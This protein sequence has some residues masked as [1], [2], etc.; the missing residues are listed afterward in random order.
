MQI[1]ATHS[2]IYRSRRERDRGFLFG[3][4]ISIM[5]DLLHIS[6]PHASV[7]NGYCQEG[8]QANIVNVFR[9]GSYELRLL[10]DSIFVLA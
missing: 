8:Y 3:A 9:K 5:S 6:I 2:G 4:R 7:F 1:K 10:P